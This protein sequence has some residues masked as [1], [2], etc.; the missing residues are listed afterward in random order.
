MVG[1][2]SSAA[3]D[4]EHRLCVIDNVN[5]GFDIYKTDSGNFMRTL[6][7]DVSQRSGVCEPL[8]KYASTW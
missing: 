2:S 7:K 1:G 6:V 4:M 8:P 3:I 5:N